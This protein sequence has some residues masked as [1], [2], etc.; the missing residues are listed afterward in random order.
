MKTLTN[1]SGQVG[2]KRRLSV[3][4]IAEMPVPQRI[5]HLSISPLTKAEAGF[6]LE[7]MYHAIYVPEG[8]EPLPRSIMK[9]PEII[10]YVE[11]WGRKDDTGFIAIDEVKQCEVGAVWVRLLTGEN[12][13]YGYVNDATPELSIAVIPEYRDR[14]VGTKLLTR[15]LKEAEGRWESISLSVTLDN[16]AV[17]LYRRFGFESVCTSGDS[18]TM[19]KRLSKGKRKK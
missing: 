9:K 10:R 4:D 8:A 11:N 14:G 5:Q 2:S 19:I 16:P 6:L 12:R 7:M 3:S 17:R 18:L 1:L 15:L 13:G